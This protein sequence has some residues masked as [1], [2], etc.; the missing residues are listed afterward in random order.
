MLSILDDMSKCT[1]CS[2]CA[3]VCH[4]NCIKMLP[5]KEGFLF[6]AIDTAKCV[7]CGL[8]RKSCPVFKAVSK[9][10]DASTDS[11][12]FENIKTYALWSK[13]DNIRIQSTSGGAF[14]VFAEKVIEDGGS[15]FGAAFN[16]DFEVTHASASSID[17]LDSLR[18]TK[19]VQSDLKQSFSEAADMLK[20][21][22]KVM[23]V[24]TP[25]QIAG[26]KSYLGREYDDLLAVEL[27]CHGVPSPKIWYM[28]LEYIKNEYTSNVRD[29]SF[30]DK[31]DG[32]MKSSMKITFENGSIYQDHVYR[33]TYIMG[34]SK[35]IFN[36]KCCFNCNFRLKNSK[37]DIVIAD[38]WGIDKLKD[39]DDTIRS[40]MQKGISLVLTRTPNGE[41]FL[42][43]LEDRTNI[44]QTDFIES[45]AGNP[46]L[47]SSCQYP[48]GREQFFRDVDKNMT[49]KKLKKKYMNNSG[50]IYNLKRIAKLILYSRK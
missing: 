48:K 29:I 8:C 28:Y 24:G 42:S 32:W 17:Q 22:K 18:R 4:K 6:P 15:V 13:S 30:R 35:G 38:F 25:C 19:Y 40:A 33:E 14:T 34:F 49:F 36:R 44:V 3:N 5:D 16:K 7:D 41:G 2:A 20:S 11:G 31:K 27:A 9:E 26:L 37:A 21:G 23:F 12:G 10:S 47:F 1:G 45:V 39:P 46:R 50:L 43:L